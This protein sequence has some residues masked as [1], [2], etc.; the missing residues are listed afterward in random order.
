MDGPI[1]PE[2]HDDDEEARRRRYLTWGAGLR[3]VAGVIAVIA[4]LIGLETR[5][6]H[7]QAPATPPS[8]SITPYQAQNVYYGDP[9]SPQALKPGRANDPARMVCT[10]EIRWEPTSGHWHCNGSTMLGSKDVGRVP[11]DPGGPCTHRTVLADSPV[12]QCITTQAVPASARK[13]YLGPVEHGVIYGG[14]RDGSDFCSQEAR[15]SK[16][17]G[18]WTCTNWRAIPLGFRFEE[19]ANEPGPCDF[20]AVDQTTGEWSCNPPATDLG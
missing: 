15:A 2:D 1:L 8:P 19:A 13:G 14:M 5:V 6:Y 17:H 7:A 16:S 3:V 20:R 11:R 4:S 10:D 9:T 12:W 18:A